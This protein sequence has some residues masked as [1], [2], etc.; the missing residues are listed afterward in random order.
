MAQRKI[1]LVRKGQRQWSLRPQDIA[2]ALKLAILDPPRLTYAALGENLRLSAA[3]THASV[4]RLIDAR[5]AFEHADIGLKTVNLALT[6]LII[7]G[8]PYVFPAVRGGPTIGIPTAYAV[9]PLK[10]QVL[11]SD[12]NP[13]VWPHAEGTTRGFGLMPL[14]PNLPSAARDDAK[15][16]SLLAMVDAIRIGQ[17][18]ERDLAAR[19]LRGLLR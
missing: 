3:E 9:K 18:R 2:V 6:N 11:F 17:A 8:V 1:V 7:H 16:Y 12:E 13:P 4:T 19:L 15:F 10:D 14:Y 5:L